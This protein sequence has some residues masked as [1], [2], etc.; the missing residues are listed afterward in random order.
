MIH[1]RL[2]QKVKSRLILLLAIFMMSLSTFAQQR[3][4]TGE[5]K[6]Q[7]GNTLPGVTVVIKGTTVGTVTNADGEFSLNVP[8]NAEALLFSFV[9]MKTQEISI[10]GK[11]NISVVMQDETIGLDEVVAIGYGTV[12]KSDLTGAVMGRVK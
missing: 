2:K 10:N 4:I 3:R 11:T 9:G 8:A 6:S 1:A 7:T 5:V 12:K